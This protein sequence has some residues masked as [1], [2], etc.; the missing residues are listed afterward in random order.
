M[1]DITQPTMILLKDGQEISR[2]RSA[3]EA[4][5]KASKSGPGTYT[6]VR[7]DA[8]IEI[9]G[10][11]VEPTPEPEPEPEPTPEPE[12]E[13]EPEPT[14]VPTDALF[15]LQDAS[16]LYQD[17][18]GTVPVTEF[19]QPVGC[20]VA[21]NGLTAKAPNDNSRPIYTE[22]GLLFDGVDDVLYTD[23]VDLSGTDEAT[24]AVAGYSP[25]K[26]GTG[27][28]PA[29]T[30]AAFWNAP[31]GHLWLYLGH[32]HKTPLF[33]SAGKGAML[34]YNGMQDE[35]VSETK[36]LSMIGRCSIADNVSS[37]TRNGITTHVQQEMGAGPF[38]EKRL[39]IGRRDLY[40]YLS[41]YVAAVYLSGRFISDEEV[42]ELD[43]MLQEKAGVVIDPAPEP[44]PEP[45]P[46][47]T[48]EPDPEPTPE[49]D[50]EPTPPPVV[51]PGTYP[52][53]TMIQGGRIWTD[54]PD[55]HYGPWQPAGDG[56]SDYFPKLEYAGS[57]TFPNKD[58]IDDNGKKV[59]FNKGGFS[60]AG[61]DADGNRIIWTT[62][63]RNEGAGTMA[64]AVPTTLDGRRAKQ[65][66][67]YISFNN[68][69]PDTGMTDLTDAFFD[70]ENGRLIVSGCCWYNAAKT[71]PDYI[72]SIDI[73]TDENGILQGDYETR[74]GWFDIVHRQSA[75]GYISDTPEEYRSVLGRYF[76]TGA[77]NMS[78]ITS[79]SPGSSLSGWDGHIPES[80]DELVSVSN[81]FK[82]DVHTMW[83][84][85]IAGRYT[86][87]SEHMSPNKP[88]S[89]LSGRLTH[90]TRGFIYNGHLWYL[91]WTGGSVYGQWY[92]HNGRNKGQH[93]GHPDELGNEQNPAA[94]KGLKDVKSAY[95]GI[96]LYDN[97]RGAL[98][99]NPKGNA[100]PSEWGYA[101]S[102]LP[103]PKLWDIRGAFF[104]YE[105]NRLYVS[106]TGG[107]PTIYVYDVV[108][109]SA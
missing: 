98:D 11:V 74:T 8:T 93:T 83:G 16:T 78:I 7:P 95:W 3:V 42:A 99:A 26:T 15:D 72:Q 32:K 27:S 62:T 36:P 97:G 13:P 101:E 85:D 34:T 94:S 50:P 69:S 106:R 39:S 87:P 105:E 25:T 53:P 76:M 55:A 14:P 81:F 37:L 18:D 58:T 82:Y 59:A 73:T 38:G 2:H 88:W 40:G 77:T 102:V 48:P 96:P 17:I 44:T 65:V 84:E 1:I 103:G 89:M 45:D 104:D 54:R 43:T 29:E 4:M 12:P 100:Q 107:A 6:L 10:D 75:A 68:W 86:W 52:R 64:F 31:Q 41:G 90:K 23:P 79:F 80:A 51:E 67:R 5:E 108:Q 20:A 33:C 46:E 47:P 61:R 70:E 109:G 30:F 49:P 92:G 60:V 35:S 24:L 71:H 56:K 21:G 28:P 63:H 91:G 22:R 9:S 19:G 57:F 66:G